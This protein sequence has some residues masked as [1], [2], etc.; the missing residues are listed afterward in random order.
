MSN[1]IYVLMKANWEP[2]TFNCWVDPGGAVWTI[3]NFSTSPDIVAGELHNLIYT[4]IYSEPVSI[5]MAKV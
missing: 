1:L 4:E 2:K 3:A 5:T